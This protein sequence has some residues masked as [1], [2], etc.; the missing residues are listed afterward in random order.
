MCSTVSCSCNVSNNMGDSS[1][2]NQM[3]GRLPVQTLIDS[4]LPIMF[5]YWEWYDDFNGPTSQLQR[6]QSISPW[7]LT[8]SY[9]PESITN[10]IWTWTAAAASSAG[11]QACAICIVSRSQIT[12]ENDSQFFFTICI[13]VCVQTAE[14]TNSEYIL[15]PQVFD[16]WLLLQ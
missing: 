3:R 1:D 4:Y 16:S 15:K 13:V 9:V 8:R 11:Y 5:P 12:I 2:S 6:I 10:K 14:P 7:Y